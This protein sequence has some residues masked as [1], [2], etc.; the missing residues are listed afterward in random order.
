LITLSLLAQ[1]VAVELLVVCKKV[2]A[3]VAQVDYVAQ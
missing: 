1:V 3:A 2:L